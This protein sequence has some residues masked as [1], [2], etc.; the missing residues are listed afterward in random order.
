[1]H[2][3]PLPAFDVQTPGAG[4]TCEST[5]RE[6]L[7]AAGSAVARDRDWLPSRAGPISSSFQGGGQGKRL[8]CRLCLSVC[9]FS[10]VNSKMRCLTADGLAAFLR[11]PCHRSFLGRVTRG[12]FASPS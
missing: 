11:P 6:Q 5:V 3:C 8:A 12:A 7:E 2:M 4:P 10:Q 9:M 1:M